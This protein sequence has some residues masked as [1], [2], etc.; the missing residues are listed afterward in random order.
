MTS[1]TDL[2]HA[3]LMVVPVI[4]TS[5]NNMLRVLLAFVAGCEDYLA[6]GRQK[7]REDLPFRSAV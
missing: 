2:Y 1:V 6:D 4:A 5:C 3:S 7:V